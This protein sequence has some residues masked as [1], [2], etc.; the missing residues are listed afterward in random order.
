MGATAGQHLNGFLQSADRHH[1]ESGYDRRFAG[2]GARDE[3]AADAVTPRLRRDRQH[4]PH[5]PDRAV[6]R[7]LAEHDR[8]AQVTHWDEPG[9]REHAEGDG[10][11]ETRTDFADIGRRE[12][13]RDTSLRKREAGVADGALDTVATL[14]HAGIGQPHQRDR[15]QPA[16]RD[17]DLDADGVG[18][19]AVNRR[20]AEYG[21]HRCLSSANGRPP[22]SQAKPDELAAGWR[23]LPPEGS[24]GMA[25]R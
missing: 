9:G 10:Q 7:E 16:I 22:P 13:D 8:V 19:D 20:G 5:R 1:V 6:E 24:D 21:K 25:R 17:V 23:I 11:V 14:T 18:V 15:R 2:V 4:T 3:D 12:V